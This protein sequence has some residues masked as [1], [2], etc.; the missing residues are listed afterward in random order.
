MPKPPPPTFYPAYCFTLSPTHNTWAKMAAADVHALQ[1]RAGFEGQGIYFYLNYPI[2]W[3]RLVGVI[4]AVDVY[5]TKWIAVLDDG[6]GRTV[7]V[8]CGRPP[9][10][11]GSGG[12]EGVVGDAVVLGGKDG[13]REDPRVGTTATGRTIDLAGVDVGTVVK[14][15]GGVGTFRGEKQLALERLCTYLDFRLRCA[16]SF[17]PIWASVMTCLF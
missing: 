16:T 6:S 1:E 11:Q 14:V 4:V 5:P 2:R 13:V 12:R 10:P 8:V 3:V 9:A 15:K 7:E 17:P